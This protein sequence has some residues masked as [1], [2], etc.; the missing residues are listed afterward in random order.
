MEDLARDYV[1]L[2]IDCCKICKAVLHQSRPFAGWGLFEGHVLTKYLA[3]SSL[4]HIALRQDL[5]AKFAAKPKAAAPKS[6]I[7]YTNICLLHPHLLEAWK[8]LCHLFVCNLI[9]V[10]RTWP[11]FSKCNWTKFQIIY[12]DVHPTNRI[13]GLKSI[14]K[15]YNPIT[16]SGNIPYSIEVTFQYMVAEAQYSGRI[17]M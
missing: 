17:H 16:L 8:P 10:C 13:R 11:C 6:V 9:F 7:F 15:P 3:A 4:H 5:Y 14:Y 2:V 12:L 1:R